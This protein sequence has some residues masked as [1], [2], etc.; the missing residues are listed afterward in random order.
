MD[1][2]ALE[3]KILSEKV[4]TL[5]QWRTSIDLARA[6]EEVEKNHLDKRFDTIE[7]KLSDIEGTGK[8][9]QWTIISAILVYVVS[10]I[11]NGGLIIPHIIK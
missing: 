8:K 9:L 10:F 3:I 6:K 4:H 1:D 11:L 2:N 5:E 7:T